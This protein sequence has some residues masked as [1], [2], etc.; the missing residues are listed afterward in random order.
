MVGGC[1]LMLARALR[2]WKA[3]VELGLGFWIEEG[4]LLVSI[5][6]IRFGG[7]FFFFLHSF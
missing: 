6:W 7:I 5:N 3:M 1:L 2:K 4:L